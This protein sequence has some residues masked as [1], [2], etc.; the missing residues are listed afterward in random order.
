MEELFE[1]PVLSKQI[2]QIEDKQKAALKSLT[3]AINAVNES[4]DLSSSAFDKFNSY[5]KQVERIRDT[6]QDTYFRINQLKTRVEQ[7]KVMTVS[8]EFHAEWCKL[9]NKPLRR[10]SEDSDKES[11]QSLDVTD[12]NTNNKDNPNDK[13]K[14]QNQDM[15]DVD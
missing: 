4:M 13:D 9:H 10:E 3:L 7:H 2:K 11:E 1:S 12:P 8:D 15:V 6:I 5:A 14:A